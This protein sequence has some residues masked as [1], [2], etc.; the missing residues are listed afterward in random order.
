M[1]CLPSEASLRETSTVTIASLT[2]TRDLRVYDVSAGGCLVES[3]EFLP[4]GTVGVLSMVFDGHHREEWIRVCRVHADEARRGTCLVSVEFLPLEPAGV[5]SLRG[6]VLQ[7]HANG[8]PLRIP[9]S[10]GRSSGDHRNSAVLFHTPRTALSAKPHVDPNDSTPSVDAND[11][12][13][14]LLNHTTRARP[15]PEKE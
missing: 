9:A 11:L 2:R 10:L 3:R 5:N 6:A 7:L 12:A 13:T 14:R 4:V 15:K 8:S 1:A